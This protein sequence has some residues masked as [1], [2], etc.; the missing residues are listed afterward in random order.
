MKIPKGY[1]MTEV[2]VVPE[3]WEA[4]KLSEIGESIIGLTY[5]PPNVKSFGTLVL[6]SSNV[7]GGKLD[8]KDNVF[9][10][11]DLPQRVIV[12][13]NDILICVRNGSR[14]LI[15]K[16][17]LI[18]ENTAGSAFGAFMTVYRSAY[19]TFVFHQF[20]SNI[21]QRQINETIGATINQITNKDLSA[22]QIPLPPTKAEQTAIATAL[23]DAD[24]LITQLEQLI[25]KKRAVKQGA[26]Q[27]LLKAKER[28]EEKALTEVVDYIHGKAHERDIDE[29]GKYIVVNSKF[30]SSEGKVAKH[31][32]ANYCPA[33]KND[34][35][36]VLS[37]LPNGK[38]LA[39]CF[40]VPENNKYA[41]NQRIC[42]WRSKG[43]DPLFLFYLLNRH[44]YFMALDDG[45]AQTHILNHHI[46]K[47]VIE[48]PNN[49]AEQT[50]I[51]RILSDMDGELSALEGQL[52]KWRGVKAGMMGVLLTGKIRLV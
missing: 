13:K 1:K 21:I 18:D 27:A 14:Q 6:R 49:I 33:R 43:A 50:R 46:E 45:V 12:R 31:S 23:N 10:E 4:H 15:G 35:L 32:H 3:D 29:Q 48:L 19:S 51:A 8:F 38:A 9:V 30:I 7:Q 47:C 20:Q 37:D 36:T 42:I 16:C 25:A 39:K 2:G 34:I 28:W 24:R 11:M 26:M 44:K 40:L 17:A 22:F 41:V 5:S 52:A